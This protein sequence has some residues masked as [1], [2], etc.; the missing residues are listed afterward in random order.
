MC[1][2]F[3][4]LPFIGPFLHLCCFE[5]LSIFFKTLV[6]SLNVIS[7]GISHLETCHDKDSKECTSVAETEDKKVDEKVEPPKEKVKKTTMEETQA[8]KLNEQL[9][10]Q[11]TT[12]RAEDSG[13]EGK[14][15]ASI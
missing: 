13:L 14:S 12:L 10:P 1:S 9:L 2:L 15:C 6:L 11:Q 5:I 3:F 8:K 7:I 4:I